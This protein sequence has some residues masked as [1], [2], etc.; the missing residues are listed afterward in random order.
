M[1]IQYLGIITLLRNALNNE[2]VPLPEGFVWDGVATLAR[3]HRLTG[4]VIQGAARCGVSRSHPVITAMTL[5]FCKQVQYGRAQ[6]RRLQQVLERF[7]AEGIEYMPIKGAVIKALYPKS[8]CRTMGDADV[9]V[10]EERLPQIRQLLL[11]LGLQELEVTSDYEAAWGDSSLKLELHTKLV[12]K[13][14]KRFAQHFGTGWQLAKKQG[15]SNRYLLSPED[16]LVYLVGHFAKH[17]LQGSICAKDLCDFWIWNRSYPDMDQAYIRRALEA[18]KLD[19][20]YENISQM[21]ACWFAGQQ[22]TEAVELMTAAAFAGGVCQQEDES[23]LRGIMRRR[24]D[25]E[26]SL[27]KQKVKWFLHAVFPSASFLEYKYPVLKKWPVLLPVYWVRRWI[28][29]LF[30]DRNKLKRG[31]MVVKMNE[32]E[33]SE[34]QHHM[35]TVGLEPDD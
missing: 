12:S 31:M 27:G 2:S 32:K 6:D 4:F 35:D 10:H 24:A 14:Y 34:Y 18:L 13:E 33:Q 15:D 26:E 17:Y 7:E 5:E 8:E 21:V 19:A 25:G 29:I 1:D 20:F 3:I 28:S 9:L 23:A 30:R 16:H 11:E 22:A